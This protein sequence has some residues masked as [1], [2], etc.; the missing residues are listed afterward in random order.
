MSNEVKS[1]KKNKKLT[2]KDI[3]GSKNNLLHSINRIRLNEN[4]MTIFLV[5]V[6]I[7][8]FAFFGFFTLKID[9]SS[10]T[11]DLAGNFNSGVSVLTSVL[12]LDSDD[13]MS[14]EDGLNS[15]PIILSINNDNADIYSYKLT[16]VD[17]D[18]YK[19]SCGCE[20]KINKEDIRYSL[21]GVTVK[22]LNNENDVLDIGS[23]ESYSGN[24][25]NI[26]IWVNDGT[27]LDDETHF[28]GRFIIETCSL[29]EN[30]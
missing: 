17:D 9:S 14:D 8:V 3:G 15:S 4:K 5:I 10:I 6:F 21:D 13:V 16:L 11:S 19:K 30:N 25:L 20:K 24:D 12:T 28:H 1:K 22:S 7:C 29:E 2:K 27:E 26:K 23:V 18:N